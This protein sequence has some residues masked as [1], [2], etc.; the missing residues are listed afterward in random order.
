MAG[1]MTPLYDARAVVRKSSLGNGPADA[2]TSC[3]LTD[4]AWKIA[5]LL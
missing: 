4:H 2:A 1:G 3:M 5:D